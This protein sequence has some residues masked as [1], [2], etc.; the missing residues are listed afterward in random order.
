MAM[1]AHADRRWTLA[2]W[3]VMALA[4]LLVLA[5]AE[6]ASACPTCKAGL[7]AHDPTQGDLV[8]AYMWSI[9]FL[10]AMP[11][12]LLASFSGYMWWLVRQAR[13]RPKPFGQAAATAKGP[14]MDAE[15]SAAAGERAPATS[16]RATSDG[17]ELIRV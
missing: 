6:A 17:R 12:T 7:A 2:G 3:L 5:L 16:E 4:I 10:M 1:I 14:S 9:L 15:Q 8:S 11:F 13:N